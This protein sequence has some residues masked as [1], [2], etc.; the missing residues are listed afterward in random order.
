MKRLLF[1]VVLLGFVL[2]A[3]AAV[4]GIPVTY[5]AGKVALKG[6]LA[7]DP[8]IKG[9]RP[10]VLVV[11]EWWGS[12]AYAHERAR[13]LAKLGYTALALDMYGNGKQAAHPKEAGEFAQAVLKNARVEK[14]RFDAAKRLLLRQPSVDPARI[15]AI[16]Y[17]FG[18]GVVL[19]IARDGEALS[20]VVSFHGL[21]AASHPAKPGEIKAPILVL[22][23]AADKMV[24]PEQ[25]EAFKKEMDAAH[26]DYKVIVYPGAGHSFTNPEATALGR[27]FH[28]PLAYDP[29]A[30]KASWAAMRAFLKTAF[31]KPRA[32]H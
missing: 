28:I 22:A 17:C 11:H 15:A 23:G 5:H 24:P 26:A 25:V 20:G 7:Y 8:A 1:A 6:Y 13:M 10:G 30:D 12:N 29:A 14:A 3:A 19:D 31:E 32:G 4:K 9:K 2:P 16:G 27:R 18:G 21:L